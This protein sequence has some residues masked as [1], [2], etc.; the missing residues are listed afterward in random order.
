MI[1]LAIVLALLLSSAA[2]MRGIAGDWQQGPLTRADSTAAKAGPTTGSEI[3]PLPQDKPMQPVVPGIL[4][5]FKNGYLFNQERMLAGDEPPPSA[6][7]EEAT[8]D[9]TTGIAA[10]LDDV[11]YTGSIIA[12]NF[13]RALIVYTEATKSAIPAQRTSRSSKVRAPSPE[14]GEKYAR[15]EVGDLVDGYQVAEI[16]A[17]KLVFAKGDETVEK[18]LY[19]PEKK[20]QAP[21]PRASMPPGGVSMPRPGGIQSTTIGGTALPV[22]TSPS[23][24]NPP[25]P[26]A[27]T[28]VAPPLPPAPVA[29][30]T[31]RSPAVP[32]PTGSSSV[33]APPVRR[34]VIS[35][36]PSTAARPDTS[37]VI[38]QTL[39]GSNNAIPLPP[40][41]GGNSNNPMATPPM[42]GGK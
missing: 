22:P 24:V 32:S 21:P 18:M 27:P 19:D 42:P 37:R 30:P 16:L 1:R 34:M 29:T 9:D 38:R 41:F 36:Q 8:P 26:P 33:A 11:S 20:R 10:K 40:G 17:D 4:P 13:S 12:D 2:M 31:V 23:G 35:R 3:V 39:G 5:D 14:G 28:A 6:E 25:I 7:G 15:L